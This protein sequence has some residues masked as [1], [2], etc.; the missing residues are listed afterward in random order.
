MCFN[1][2]GVIC[3]SKLHVKM[4]KT[5]GQTI[6]FKHILFCTCRG[7]VFASRSGRAHFRTKCLHN[8]KLTASKTSKFL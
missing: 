2:P 8:E 5:I 7:V 3:A 6:R 4:R 1:A